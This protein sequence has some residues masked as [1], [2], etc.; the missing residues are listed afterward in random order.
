MLLEGHHNRILDVFVETQKFLDP[1]KYHPDAHG[2]KAGDRPGLGI[3]KLDDLL[4]VAIAAFGVPDTFR[5]LGSGVRRGRG[6]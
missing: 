3:D 6:R 2:G 1:L 4:R 5:E